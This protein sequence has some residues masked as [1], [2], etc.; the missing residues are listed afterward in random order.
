M[1]FQ[2]NAIFNKE[3]TLLDLKWEQTP[4]TTLDVKTQT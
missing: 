3:H 4:T 2:S 1:D